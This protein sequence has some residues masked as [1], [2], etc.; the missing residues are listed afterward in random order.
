MEINVKKELLLEALNVASKV[1][2][3]SPSITTIGGILIEAKEKEVWITATNLETTVRIPVEAEVIKK[4]ELLIPGK[5][6]TSLIKQIDSEDLKISLGENKANLQTENSNYSFLT[7]NYEEFPKL[8]KFSGITKFKIDSKLLKDMVEKTEFCIYPE[9]PRPHFRGGLLEIK[10]NILKMVATDTKRLSVFSTPL[11]EKSEDMRVLLPYKLLDFLPDILKKEGEIE[12]GIG[13]NQI[14]F[15]LN[16]I[17]IISQ[18]LEGAEDFPDY[19]RVIPEE[20][21]LKIANIDRDKFLTTLKRIMVFTS[22]RHNRI[23]L[24]FGNKRLMISVSSPEIGQAE[25]KMEIDYEGEE[26]DIAFNPDY[27]VEFL[28]QVDEEEIIFGFTDET[29]PVL[30]RPKDRKDYIYVAMPLKLE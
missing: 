25:E 30:M 9:E 16:G 17:S 7:M 29:K 6:F 21:K 15:K 11:E 20:D 8:P 28:Q 4:G 23:K 1:I 19:E 2:P 24:S 26:Q 10:E 5:K 3:S 27:L 22:E 14:L 12:I 18:L 13:K